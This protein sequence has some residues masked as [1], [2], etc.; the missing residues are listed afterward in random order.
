V[1]GVITT[2]GDCVGPDTPVHVPMI[3][4]W[5]SL[6]DHDNILYYRKLGHLDSQVIVYASSI[7]E[8]AEECFGFGPEAFSEAF[9]RGDFEGELD[10]PHHNA[11]KHGPIDPQMEPGEAS[12][13]LNSVL[14][15]LP[16][17]TQIDMGSYNLEQ[18]YGHPSLATPHFRLRVALDTATPQKT[19]H[20][21]I[22]KD[23]R[24]TPTER[25]WLPGGDDYGDYQLSGME[26]EAVGRSCHHG[27]PACSTHYFDTGLQQLRVFDECAATRRC[28][29]GCG[30]S[31]APGRT[32]KGNAFDT[33]A[34]NCLCPRNESLQALSAAPCSAP[35]AAASAR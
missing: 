17:G 31:I 15:E 29:K 33:C 8:V 12:L 13:V 14:Q 10:W 6:G 27:F 32:L 24:E 4:A 34:C 22:F 23:H 21:I 3:P 7:E 30:H 5:I 35:G 16:A 9:G 19:M 11:A 1:Q 26:I 28:R 2:T 20:E 25:I 18:G